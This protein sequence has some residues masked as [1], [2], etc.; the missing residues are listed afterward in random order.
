MVLSQSSDLSFSSDPVGPAIPTLFIKASIFFVF[1]ITLLKKSETWYSF[2][3]SQRYVKSLLFLSGCLF[4][5][6]SDLLSISQR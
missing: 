3:A 4:N 2:G 5:L 1:F 6:A